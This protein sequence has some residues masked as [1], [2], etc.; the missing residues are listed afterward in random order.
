[1]SLTFYVLLWAH[2][3]TDDALIRYE[4]Q[5]LA[6]VPDHGGQI[7]QRARSDGANGCPVEIQLVEF[8]SAQAFAAYMADERRTALAAQRDRA[9]ARTELIP[10]R[11]V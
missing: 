4:D 9:I 3:G 7:L 11:M 2:P 10:V 8:P 5:V 1:M 6:L